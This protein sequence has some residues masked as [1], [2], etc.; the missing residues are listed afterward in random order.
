MRQRSFDGYLEHARVEDLKSMVRLYGGKLTRKDECIAFV[1]AALADPEQVRAMLDR[2]APFERAALGVLKQFGGTVSADGLAVA[3]RTLGVPLPTSKYLQRDHFL[4]LD[5]LTR[6]GLMQYD[7][8]DYH[9]YSYSDYAPQ[10]MISD[11][12]I[13][14]HV[15]PPQ[16]NAFKIA[17]ITR[18][19]SSMHMR[20]PQSV[21]LQMLSILNAI[22][23]MGSLRL[24]KT[25]ARDIR[26]ADLNKLATTLKWSDRFEIDG[27][28]F[29]DPTN[30]FV[31]ALVAAELLVVQGD[32]LVL[33][34]SPQQFAEQTYAQQVG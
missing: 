19:P 31:G 34:V 7:S 26:T 30:A 10:T 11:A 22:A 17:P 15:G 4:L 21:A 6:H 9:A 24:N 1:K 14:A 32:A 8:Q 23:Q 18:Q 3:I 33:T 12:R 16:V 29:P 2:V 5:P 13:L 28:P 27:L 20:R 25:R